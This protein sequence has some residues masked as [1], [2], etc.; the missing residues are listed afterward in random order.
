M[1]QLMNPL[2]LLVVGGNYGP[3]MM[4]IAEILGK[5]EFLRRIRRGIEILRD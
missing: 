3:G 1:G 5:Q 2:R 4:D